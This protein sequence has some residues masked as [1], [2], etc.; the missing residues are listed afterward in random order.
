MNMVEDV[1]VGVVDEDGA[2]EKPADA[3]ELLAEPG[4]LLRL[5]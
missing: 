5:S 1:E 3:F 2:A 4:K